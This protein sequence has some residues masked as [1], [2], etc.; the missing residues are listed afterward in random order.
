[1]SDAIQL[2]ADA[3]KPIPV[4]Q[5]N[6]PKLLINIYDGKNPN[7]DYNKTINNPKLKDALFVYLSNEGNSGYAGGSGDGTAQIGNY[8]NT[9]GIITGILNNTSNIESGGFQNL[10]ETNTFRLCHRAD[11]KTYD[12]IPKQAIDYLLG[13]LYELIQEKKYRYLILPCDLDPTA[14][15]DDYHK[16]TLGAGIFNVNPTVKR[17]IYEQICVMTKAPYSDGWQLITVFLKD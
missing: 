9:F 12:V 3:I 4:D 2:D 14:Q 13:K 10:D 16:Y 8:E 11:K 1:V 5:K 15:R 17:Y 7:T 6:K